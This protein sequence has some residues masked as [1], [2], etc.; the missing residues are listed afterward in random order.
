M[1]Q[2]L[3]NPNEMR[4]CPETM[5]YKRLDGKCIYCKGKGMY[6]VPVGDD[7]EYDN[8]PNNCEVA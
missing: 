2:P 6:A 3:F 7:M 1:Y 8:C 5:S 4:F